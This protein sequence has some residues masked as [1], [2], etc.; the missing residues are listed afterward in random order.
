M[1]WET[2]IQPFAEFGF[3]RRALLG[4]MAISLGATPVGVFLMLRR[5]S[6]TGCAMASAVLPGA[7]TGYLIFGL[8]LVPMTFGGLG[9]GLAVA[10]LSGFVTRR[11][12]LRE[13]SS[14]AAFSLIALALGV[15]IVSMRGNNMDLM[16]VLFGMVLALDDTTLILLCSITSFSLLILSLLLRPLVLECVDPCSFARLA[17]SVHLPTS[18]SLYSL[19]SIL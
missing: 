5:I 9:A 2:V 6:L 12:Q 17:S 19:F 7:A 15:L 14:L 16:R 3:M 10:L 1:I 13:D 8:S 18:P 11:T 4:C